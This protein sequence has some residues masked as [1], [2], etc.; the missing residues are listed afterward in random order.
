MAA[1]ISPKALQL[2]YKAFKFRSK[3]AKIIRATLFK[4]FKAGRAHI[5][6]NHW[7]LFINVLSLYHISK[8]LQSFFK[9]T[10]LAHIHILGFI[11]V[12][13]RDAH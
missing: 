10:S 3:A 2:C 12:M 8:N 4:S 5:M 6:T 7:Y 13:N 1:S 11:L 9:Q